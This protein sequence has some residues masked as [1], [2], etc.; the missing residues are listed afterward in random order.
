[1]K[2]IMIP[3]LLLTSLKTFSQNT[4][5]SI[6]KASASNNFNLGAD[7][8]S[9]Y[10]WRGLQFGGNSPSLQPYVE[11]TT[12]KF[13]IGAWAAYSLS[14]A[15][16]NQEVD[17]YLTYSPTST[18]SITVTDYFFPTEGVKQNYFEYGNTT[19]HVYEAM[20]SFS[21]TDT[22][23]LGLTLATNFAGADK[24]GNKQSYS[25]YIEANY[26]TKINDTN[27]TLFAG[28]VFAD[29][30]SYYQTTGSDFI[31]LGL[32]VSKEV[33]ITKTYKLPVNATIIFNPDQ[34]NIYLTFGFSL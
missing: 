34:E 31:N 18:L 20:V 4:L 5:D 10:I 15:N 19:G 7:F 24:N 23:P 1:M 28:A 13:A 25:T 2:K 33:S 17:L 21:G 6:P 27:L 14:G 12:G 16:K 11:Y 3:I 26:G 22:F 30:G 8:K 32:S 29:N 9:R